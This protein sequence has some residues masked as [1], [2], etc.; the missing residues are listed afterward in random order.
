MKTFANTLSDNVGGGVG[1]RGVGHRRLCERHP[2]AE[3][4][5][6]GGPVHVASRVARDVLA[7]RYLQRKG[8]ASLVG[9]EG[10]DTGTGRAHPARPSMMVGLLSDRLSL[11]RLQLQDEDLVQVYDDALVHL[12]HRRV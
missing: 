6:D 12:L 2:D 7:V 3:P 10:E 4:V 5:A 1:L 8:A 11:R 9:R